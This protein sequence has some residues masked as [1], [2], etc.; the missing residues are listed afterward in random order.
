MAEQGLWE[1]V[2]RQTLLQR[3]GICGEPR[4]EGT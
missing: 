4:L 1:L 3:I 2:K